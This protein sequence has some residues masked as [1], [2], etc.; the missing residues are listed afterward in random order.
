[1]IIPGCTAVVDERLRVITELRLPDAPVQVPTHKMTIKLGKSRE[2]EIEWHEVPFTDYCPQGIGEGL[3]MAADTG[4]IVE[5]SDEEMAE[6]WPAVWATRKERILFDPRQLKTGTAEP[7]LDLIER[8][9]Q[10]RLANAR[11]ATKQAHEDA[12]SAAK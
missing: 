6:L 11:A 8:A 7:M 10:D 3:Q 4:V 5:I 9:K 2:D 1:M 12:A